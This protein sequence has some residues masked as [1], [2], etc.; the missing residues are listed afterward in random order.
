ME[1]HAYVMTGGDGISSVGW[2]GPRSSA[3][4]IIPAFNECEAIAG[5]VDDLQREVS[6]VDRLVV[7]DGSSDRTPEIVDELGERHL[8][9]DCNVGYGR[10]LQAGI[11]Y[12][13]QNQYDVIVFLDGDGQH[14]ARDIPRLIRA[15]DELK[16]DVVIGSRFSH[17]RAYVGPVGRR[18]GQYVFSQV[19]RLLGQRIH[20]TTSGFKA[21]RAAAC[22]AV[23]DGRFLDFHTEVLVR[24]RLLGFSIA[25]VPI[26]VRERA[27]GHSMHSV[28]SAIKYP[29][30]TF[31][32]TVVG[33]LDA[34]S[35]GKVR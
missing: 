11:R 1:A 31:L 19:T 3:L 22:R 35:Q 8:R 24:L 26:E 14:C 6:A 34:L 16:T 13:L 25:E 10:A 27:H 23:V 5:V 7:T 20:D 17:G 4:V 28:A 33:V 2:K 21:M 12:A 15:L 29:V 32:L 18:I 30:K 9:L